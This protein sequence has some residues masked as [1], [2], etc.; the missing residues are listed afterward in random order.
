MCPFLNPSFARCAA[1]G[2]LRVIL[3][4]PPLSRLLR[5]TEKR[6]GIYVPIRFLLYRHFNALSRVLGIFVVKFF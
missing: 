2:A 1:L 4:P 5:H 6:T 3:Q